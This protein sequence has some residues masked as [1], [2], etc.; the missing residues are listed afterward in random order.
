MKKYEKPLLFLIETLEE[1]VL[2]V[3]VQ[4]GIDYNLDWL[5]EGN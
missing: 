5:P 4:S 3:S 1:D 2:N